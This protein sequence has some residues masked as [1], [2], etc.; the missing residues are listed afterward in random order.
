MAAEIDLC[1]AVVAAVNVIGAGLP[2]P[3]TAQFWP[4]ADIPL[5]DIKDIAVYVIANAAVETPG[6]LDGGEDEILTISVI[7]V[8]NMAKGD[9]I[10]ELKG[11][12]GVTNSI[13]QAI[14]DDVSSSLYDWIKCDRNPL[15]DHDAIGKS[16]FIAER[17]IDW[18]LHI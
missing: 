10:E 16:I 3:A 2:I 4:K 18:R 11:L 1:E 14:K 12:L 6:T 17:T 7:V 5:E 13:V 9:D 8:R 15:Y